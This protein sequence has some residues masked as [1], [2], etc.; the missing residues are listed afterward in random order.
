MKWSINKIAKIYEYFRLNLDFPVDQRH[1]YHPSIKKMTEAVKNFYL[2]AITHNSN[3]ST[4]K[5]VKLLFE[6]ELEIIDDKSIIARILN[7][8]D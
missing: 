3:I 4:R 8:L 7:N 1:S 5:T 6:S 2:D